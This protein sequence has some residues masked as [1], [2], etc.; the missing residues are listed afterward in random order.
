MI[1][2]H[3]RI[4]RVECPE[5]GVLQVKVPWAE[6]KGRFTLLMERL[7]IDVL[8]ECASVSRTCRS[9]GSAGRRLGTSWS[10]PSGEDRLGRKPPQRGISVSMKRPF[11]KV[12]IT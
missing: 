7:N 10:E 6:A 5:H 8:C 12:M 3:A 2:V 1:F 11:V 9:C 4:P